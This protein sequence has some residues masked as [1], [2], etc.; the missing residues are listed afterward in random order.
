MLS[1]GRFDLAEDR[2]ERRIICRSDEHKIRAGGGEFVD[3]RRVGQRCHHRLPL[4]RTRRDRGAF[5]RKE[6]PPKV[7][8][9]QFI[10]IDVAPGRRVA[11]DRVVVPAVPQPAHHLDS[12]RGFVD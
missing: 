1:I 12:I 4:G 5:H 9:V 6:F 8:V 7:D 11:D 10:P 2:V 3:T